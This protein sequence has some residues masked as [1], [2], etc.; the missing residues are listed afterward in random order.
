ME[1][2]ISRNHML[3]ETLITEGCPSS[4][5]NQHHF[6]N[7]DEKPEVE[8]E[9]YERLSDELVACRA[10]IKQTTT[11]STATTTKMAIESP[12][13]ECLS[14]L[15]L[16]E[17]WRRD[18]YGSSIKPKNGDRNCGTRDMRNMGQPW[19][20]FAGDVG[21]RLLNRCVPAYSCGTHVAIWSDAAM[22]SK[23]GEVTKLP[24]YGSQ[25][26]N[27]R[28]ELHPI[29]VLRCSNDPNDFVYRYDGC[30]EVF[31]CGFCSMK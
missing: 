8:M 3:L 4:I 10:A 23:I 18:Y 9:R 7:P 15:N 13:A 20:R 29:S 2:F 11:T 1:M 28:K 25:G 19:F 16:T 14:A 6:R 17:S 22:P 26:S 31:Y 27:C 12:P 30:T 21:R 5:N 24:A